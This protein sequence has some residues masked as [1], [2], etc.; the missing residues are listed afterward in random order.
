MTTI[1]IV[2]DHYMTRAGIERVIER[3]PELRVVAAVAAT[4]DLGALPV[5]PDVVVLDLAARQVPDPAGVIA[6]LAAGSAV[7]VLSGISCGR[8]L[9]SL[10]QAGASGMVTRDTGADEFVA[11]VEAVAIGSVYLAP[12]VARNVSAELKHRAPGDPAGLGRREIETLRLVAH[13]YT[14]GQIARRM[15]LTEVTVS[16]YVKRIRAKLGAGNKAELTRIAIDLGYATAGRE[17]AASL[18]AAAGAA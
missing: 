12:G 10:L 18:R 5:R 14:H 17:P 2:A 6:D 16:T 13:G 7:L 15:G 11:A 3:R 1:A 9:L 8:E 4:A